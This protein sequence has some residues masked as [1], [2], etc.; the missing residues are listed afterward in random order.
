MGK[1]NIKLSP[2]AVLLAAGLFLA[3]DIGT[4][5]A[6]FIPVIVH[7]A[8][9]IAVMR[10]L[11]LRIRSVSADIT[12]LCIGY[13]GGGLKDEF[14]SALA[15]PAAG[16]IYALAVSQLGEVM[17]NELLC[18]S[19]GI[20]L[21]FSLFNFLP[22][23]PL[24]GGRILEAVLMAKYDVEKCDSILRAVGI[25]TGALLLAAAIWLY[26][27][28]YGAALLPAGVKILGDNLIYKR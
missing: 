1:V 26:L 23:I 10:L 28:H 20:S 19:A 6:V 22:A 2:A 24:D 9:H 8:G 4:F 16:L 3:L 11:R 5:A 17:K 13:S 12:G 14:Y 18:T 25:I 21:L 15:G 27:N 7:E